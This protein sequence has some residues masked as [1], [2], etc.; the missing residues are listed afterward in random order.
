MRDEGVIGLVRCSVD[1]V[2]SSLYL[3]AN[4]RSS[5]LL[6]LLLLPSPMNAVSLL[7]SLLTPSDCRPSDRMAR[8]RLA[9]PT[10][11]RTGWPVKA[12]SSALHPAPCVTMTTTVSQSSLSSSSWSRVPSSSLACDSE[13]AQIASP[14]L[15]FSGLSVSYH[16]TIFFK[17]RLKRR[18][19]LLHS[20]PYSPPSPQSSGDTLESHA[21]VQLVDTQASLA[22]AT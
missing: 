15:S 20:S 22:W 10:S 14:A 18:C 16:L 6:S 17:P 9:R 5:W 4:E 19:M 1:A 13:A 21:H 2:T 12:P 8:E 3:S 11:V 7:R